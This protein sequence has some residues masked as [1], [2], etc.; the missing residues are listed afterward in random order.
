MKQGICV[1][2]IFIPLTA[3]APVKAEEVRYF[4]T[5]APSSKLNLAA[6]AAIV[7]GHWGIENTLHYRKDMLMNEDR[8]NLG[9]GDGPFNLSMMRSAALAILDRL[10]LPFIHGATTPQKATFL[11]GNPQL[12]V[13]LINGGRPLAKM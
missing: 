2:K 6:A 13:A 4:A 7:R 12:A 5:S 3:E 9:T 10:R 8:H 11:Q 1:R